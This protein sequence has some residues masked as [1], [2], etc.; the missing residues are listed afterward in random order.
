VI[1][2]LI[3]GVGSVLCK[4]MDFCFVTF[5][6]FESNGKNLLLVDESLLKKFYS[7]SLGVSHLRRMHRLLIAIS[8]IFF[9]S[10]RACWY[11]LTLQVHC[12]S[13]VESDFFARVGV[14]FELDCLACFP[15]C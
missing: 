1:L 11:Q 15:T 14:D 8:A 9:L 5:C 7:T 4:E 13:F 2:I 6:H 3:S 12:R 10:V